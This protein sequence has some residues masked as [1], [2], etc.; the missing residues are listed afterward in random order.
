[1][2]GGVHELSLPGDGYK[3]LADLLEQ[4]TKDEDKR[5]HLTNKWNTSP[6]LW[7]GCF[8]S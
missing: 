5:S 6:A 8:T 3:S 2:R 4:E 7:A 1:M